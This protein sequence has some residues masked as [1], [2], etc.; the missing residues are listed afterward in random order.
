MKK[1]LAVLLLLVIPAPALADGTT[2]FPGLYQTC[3]AWTPTD[4]SG[5]SLSL[6]V[7]SANY[8]KVGK[9]VTFQADI[10]YPTNSSGAA[11]A[12]SVPPFTPAAYNQALSVGFG[13]LSTSIT[14]YIGGVSGF[15]MFPSFGGVSGNAN[16]TLSTD[17]ILVSGSYTATS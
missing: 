7:T 4:Q 2:V 1:F 8:C 14:A 12:V 17:H 3:A 15:I 9:V 11:A 6:T 16:V 13:S 10:T 5:A